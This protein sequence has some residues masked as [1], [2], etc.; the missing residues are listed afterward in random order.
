MKIQEIKELTV[1]ELSK[2]IVEEENNLVDLRF[3]HEL[4]QLTNTAKLNTIKKDIAKMKTVLR[5]RELEAQKADKKG[6]KV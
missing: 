3:A 1:E 4:K 6:A 5:Q 2:R